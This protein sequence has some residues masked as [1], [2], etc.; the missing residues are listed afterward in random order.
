MRMAL[1]CVEK[2]ESGFR[3]TA[4]NVGAVLQR[5]TDLGFVCGY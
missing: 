2:A 4:P 1:D 3:S 5:R